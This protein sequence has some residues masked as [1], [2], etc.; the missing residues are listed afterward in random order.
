[1]VAVT[2]TGPGGEERFE[3]RFVIDATGRD[4]FMAS[5]MRS[6]R[7]HPQLNRAAIS[8]HWAGARYQGGIEEGLLQIIYLGGDKQGWIWAIPVGTDRVSVGVVLNHAHL[9]KLREEILRAGSLDWQRDVYLGELFS[10]PFMS[11]VL[12][13]AHTIQPLMFNGDYSYSVSVKYGENFA[14]VGDASAFID[15]I[16]ASGVYL[17][18]NSSRL[19]AEAVDAQLRSRNGEGKTALA[20]AY[21]RIEGA[22]GLVD[23]AIRMFYN[24]VAINF[25]Q[26][27]P[28]SELIH[29][30]HENAMA[31]GHYLL[32][33]DFFEHHERYGRFLDMLAD[34]Q[35]LRLYRSKVIER[36]EY[37]SASCDIGSVEIFAPQLAEHERRRERLLAAQAGQANGGGT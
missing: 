31:V 36:P 12:T 34:P 35:I 1:L 21:A 32:A 18:M 3:A 30:Y 26:L 23:K 8:T 14:L 10:S 16:F 15:P 9:R 24:P 11:E 2:A 29:L 13:D 27:G 6:K 19:V 25:A 28:A 4:T 20:S 33:G 22:Y 17:S 7:A 5:R 37:A